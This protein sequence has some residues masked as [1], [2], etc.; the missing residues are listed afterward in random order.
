MK[1]LCEK[2]NNCLKTKTKQNENE[3]LQYT[4]LFGIQW[5]SNNYLSQNFCFLINYFSRDDQLKPI[6]TR[7]NGLEL[8]T[9]THI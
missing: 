4:Q 1:Y 7:I 6:D 2:K 3:R 9:N 8:S 5:Y